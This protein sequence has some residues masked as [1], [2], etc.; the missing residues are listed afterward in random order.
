[1]R[2]LVGISCG[3]GGAERDVDHVD[4][5]MIYQLETRHSLSL[6]V[7]VGHSHYYE[8]L[9]PRELLRDASALSSCVRYQH[10]YC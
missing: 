5:L 9:H 4:K 6:S 3:G 10:Q 1:M 7:K 8:Q 2:G